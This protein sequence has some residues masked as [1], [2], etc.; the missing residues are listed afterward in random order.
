MQTLI[1]IPFILQMIVIF[2]DEALFHIKRDLPKWERIGHPLDTL[3]VIACFAFVFW[4]PFERSMIPWYIAL[5]LFSTFFVTKDEFVHKEHCPAAEQWL[6]SVLFVNHSVVLS[7]LGLIW[8][9]L[10]EIQIF[11]FL[12]PLPQLHFLI[13]SQLTGATLFCLYQIVYWNFI[14]RPLENHQ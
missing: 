1:F 13:V 14:R 5:A 7:V 3:T 9:H 10:H 12:P 11:A 4:V 8:P 2:L 6:H